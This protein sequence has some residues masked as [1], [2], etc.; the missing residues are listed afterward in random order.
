MESEK[1]FN[2]EEELKNCKSIEDLIG[3]NGLIKNMIKDTLERLLQA[4]LE[5]HLG[6]KKHEAKGKNSGNSRNGDYSKT[7]RSSLGEIEVDVP[8]DRNGE[9]DPKLIKKHSKDISEFDEKIISMYAK[10]MTTRDIQEHVK[11]IYGVDISPT[12]VSLITDKVE[13]HIIEW[14]SRV[15]A[16]V[17]SVVY[18]DAIHY[19][20]RENGKIVSKAAYTCLG[21]DIEGHKDILGIWIGENEGAKFWATIFHE[22]KNRG[23]KDILIACMD[24]LKG[25]TEALNSI[26]PETE[27]QL[28]VVHMIRNSYKFVGS[29]NQKEFLQDLKKVYQA[30]SE[31]DAVLNLDELKFKWG[32]KYPLAVN[33]WVNNWEKV[34][35]Y[36]KYPAVLRRIIYTTNAV[37]GLHRQFR[38]VTKTRAVLPNDGALLKILFLA[39]K[40]IQKK[41]TMPVP[42]WSEIISQLNIFFEGRIMIK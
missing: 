7:I 23:V 33:P 2:Y 31:Q 12:L 41:W 24:G 8:R 20:V 11:E 32:S 39:G 10:G 13:G 38:K 3:K 5:E 17:Y 25:L 21:I 16:T 6:Y 14:Q 19:K 37:E 27:V 1:K 22:L 15:L 30:A 18:F 40:D 9:F 28:C 26:Y 36:F 35:A 4:E 42:N 34:S 29:K